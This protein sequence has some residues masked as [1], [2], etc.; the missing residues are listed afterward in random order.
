V[1]PDRF[2]YGDCDYSTAAWETSVVGN[3]FAEYLFVVNGRDDDGD[4]YIDEQFDGINNNNDFYPAGH[5]YSG[6]P[7]IDP[8]FNGI[9]D[10]ENGLIDEPSELLLFH[11]GTAFVY[12]PA[13]AEYE[14]DDWI[15]TPVA[16][17]GGDLARTYAIL[18]RPMPA[19]DSREVQLP[20]NTVIDLTT[21]ALPILGVGVSERSRVPIDPYTGYID[22]LIYPTGQI[23][24]STHTGNFSQAYDFPTFSLWI[25]TR[26]D[27]RGPLFGVDANG[28]LNPNP[29]IDTAATPPRFTY[30]MP[31]HRGTQFYLD[32]DD[33]GVIDPMFS[34]QSGNYLE[35]DRRMVMIDPR[36]G[37]AS[38]SPITFNPVYFSDMYQPPQSSG[39]GN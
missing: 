13:L 14:P 31:M 17:G 2:I 39:T 6:Q 1:N 3:G 8:G 37:R 11:N 12:N 5:A 15:G 36:T 33:D 38:V 9:D 26:E 29:G 10:N 24:P 23:V 32:H 27:I 25:A 28:L 30:H 35:G 19:P 20:G 16:P 7:I 34:A 4:G 22:F 18:R 21:S